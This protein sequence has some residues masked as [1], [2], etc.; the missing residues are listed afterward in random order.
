MFEI[1]LEEKQL[2]NNMQYVDQRTIRYEIL[3]VEQAVRLFGDNSHG[4]GVYQ[5]G[6]KYRK[7]K[8]TNRIELTEIEYAYKLNKYKSVPAYP[9]INMQ[10]A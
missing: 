5:I 2:P 6:F 8:G 3:S 9:F 10:Q 7:N 4:A 1:T